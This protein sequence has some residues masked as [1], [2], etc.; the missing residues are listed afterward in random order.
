MSELKELIELARDPRFDSGPMVLRLAALAEQAE[1]ER[2]MLKGAL[3]IWGTH[4]Q[5]CEYRLGMACDCGLEA[6][7]RPAA[8]KENA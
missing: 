1:G 3:M 8:E 5:D 7:L 2:Q 6:A 4:N